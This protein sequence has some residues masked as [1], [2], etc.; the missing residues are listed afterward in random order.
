MMIFVMCD[1]IIINFAGECIV[2][3]GNLALPFLATDSIDELTVEEQGNVRRQYL[4]GET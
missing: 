2:F 4:G 1:D 3:F